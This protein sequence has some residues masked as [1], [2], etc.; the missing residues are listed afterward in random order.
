MFFSAAAGPQRRSRP[1]IWTSHPTG[2]SPPSGHARARPKV[3]EAEGVKLF[4]SRDVQ[5]KLHGRPKN[6]SLNWSPYTAPP[7]LRPTRVDRP[8][9]RTE[10][11]APRR[12]PPRRADFTSRLLVALRRPSSIASNEKGTSEP[13]R[14][15][16][17]SGARAGVRAQACGRVRGAG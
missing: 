16:R 7:P 3:L 12:A 10:A 4:K 13:Q 11:E 15:R 8:N 6:R 9:G 14:C 1:Q 2:I 5:P 17:P